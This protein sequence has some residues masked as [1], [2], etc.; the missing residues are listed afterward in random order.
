M[1]VALAHDYLFQNG[2]AERVV[3]AMHELFP[4]APLYVLINALSKSKDWQGIKTKTSFLQKMPGSKKHLQFYLSLMPL[5]WESFN[6]TDYDIVLSSTSNL[7]KGLITPAKGLHICYCHTPTRYLWD[8]THSYVDNLHYPR[9][10]KKILPL[11]LHKLRLWDLFAAQRVDHFIANSKY[12]SRQ[13]KKYYNRESVII[14][15]PVEV[16]NYS[17]SSE[18]KDYYVLVSRLRPYKKVDIAVRA[19]NELGLPLIIIGSGDELKRLKKIAKANITFLGEVDEETKIKYVQ[20]AKAFIHPQVED[21]GISA[22]EAMAAGRP[23]IAFDGGGARETVIDNI[24][25]VLFSEQSWET[26]VYTVLNFDHTKFD[27]SIIREHA[28][29]FSVKR[30]QDEIKEYVD[31]AWQNFNNQRL[32]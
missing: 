8:G 32:L 21:F 11:V 7:A 6:F 29:K 23:V 22:V 28:L 2:G 26:L 24:T 9:I 20:E 13:I 17:I 30:F 15:P 18:I 1:K 16:D 27:P 25:G 12:I 5:A 14:Y 31:K 4:K 19:F 10:I 3:L